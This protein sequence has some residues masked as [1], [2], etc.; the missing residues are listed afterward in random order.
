MLATSRRPTT[1]KEEDWNV[2]EGE[3]ET[4]IIPGWAV[5]LGIF[6]D[7]W[8]LIMMENSAKEKSD[9][10]GQVDLYGGSEIGRHCYILDFG[11]N[12]YLIEVLLDLMNLLKK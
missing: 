5:V 4:N 3:N 8:I 7:I 11:L 6:S 1:Q 2:F 12:S 10:W 9:Y